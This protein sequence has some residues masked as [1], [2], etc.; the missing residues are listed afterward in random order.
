MIDSSKMIRNCPEVLNF[1]RLF[2]KLN[3]FICNQWSVQPSAEI[4]GKM[5]KMVWSQVATKQV[6]DTREVYLEIQLIYHNKGMWP[7]CGH[8]QL[9]RLFVNQIIVE[10]MS[11]C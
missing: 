6:N 11:S 8:F 1:N 5:L 9:H 2:L 3:R 10:T 7:Y 4:S